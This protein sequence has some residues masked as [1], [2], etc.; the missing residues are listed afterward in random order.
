MEKRQTTLDYSIV[1]QV[2]LLRPKAETTDQALTSFFKAVLAF[3]ICCFL[4]CSKTYLQ[5]LRSCFNAE[6]FTLD[7]SRASASHSTGEILSRRSHSRDI[8]YQTEGFIPD[9][10]GRIEISL[11]HHS[12]LFTS[13]FT[14]IKR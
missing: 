8:R 3:L 10:Q 5:H 11:I 7:A 14:V 6:S 12:A 4:K 1:T 2:I 13:P 9:V